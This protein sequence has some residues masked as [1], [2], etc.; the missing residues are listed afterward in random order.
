VFFGNHGNLGAAHAIVKIAVGFGGEAYHVIAQ[1]WIRWFEDGGIEKSFERPHVV[2]G[3]MRRS[4]F[5]NGE[6]TVRRHHFDV[7]AIDVVHAGLVFGAASHESSEGGAKWDESF[8][9]QTS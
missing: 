1:I 3:L 4:V 2:D 6:T 8:Q 5:A 7:G 9:A